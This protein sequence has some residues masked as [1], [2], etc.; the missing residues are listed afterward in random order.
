M[1]LQQF[2]DFTQT[3]T[4]AAGTAV[5]P[6]SLEIAFPTGYRRCTGIKVYKHQAAFTQRIGFE[7]TSGTIF[8]L[9]HPDDWLTTTAIPM[10]QRWKVCDIPVDIKVTLRYSPLA[11]V[12]TTETFDIV[13]HLVR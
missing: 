10:D 7:N 9:T 8:E 13:F 11:V 1:A 6:Y 4:V 5:S 12:P 3:H 2:M